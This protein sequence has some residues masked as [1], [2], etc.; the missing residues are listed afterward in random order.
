M[1]SRTEETRVFSCR[2]IFT[3]L[4]NCSA[5]HNV[6][7]SCV[8]FHPSLPE[9]GKLR[10]ESRFVFLSNIWLRRWDVFSIERFAAN[11]LCTEFHENPPNTLLAD[12]WS[13]T[14]GRI[15]IMK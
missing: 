1:Y 12:S 2:G 10:V 13:R 9:S 4:T 6:E 8:K 3:K 14:A 7:T 15:E 11:D 5:A